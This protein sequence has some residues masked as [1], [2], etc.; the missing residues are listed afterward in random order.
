MK[1]IPGQKTTTARPA[2]STFI[3]IGTP[4]D[5]GLQAVADLL[6]KLAR[7]DP[8]YRHDHRCDLSTLQQGPPRPQP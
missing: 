7:E 4:C 8:R 2:R 1:V 5:E 3:S 6:L